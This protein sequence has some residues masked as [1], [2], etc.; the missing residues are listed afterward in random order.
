ML[1]LKQAAGK[2]IQDLSDYAEKTLREEAPEKT[3]ALKKSI[4][5]TVSG[6]EAEIGSH[7]PYTIY[8]EYGTR[9]HVITPVHAHALSFE[10]GGETVFA[11]LV[12]HPGTKPNPFV[13]RT[14]EKTTRRI[15]QVW[16]NVW[17]AVISGLLQIV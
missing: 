14:A 6:L 1:N 2:L 16:R 12:H 13:R 15:P 11:K 7:V 17:E 3:G 5:K 10:V 9:P 4:R 8:V